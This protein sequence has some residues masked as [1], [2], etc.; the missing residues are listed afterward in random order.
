MASLVVPP[1][2]F[3]A[4]VRATGIRGNDRSCLDF[5]VPRPPASWRAS[6]GPFALSPAQRLLERD[7][8]PVRLGGRALDLL[9]ALVDLAG[10]TV[11]KTE[12]MARVW[13]NAVVDE[14]TLR[15][16]LVAVR[17]A[18]GE[19]LGGQRYIV[20]TASKG[21]TFVAQVVRSEADARAGAPTRRGGNLPAPH[22]TIVGREDEIP[23]LV[24]TLLQHRL[25]SVVGSGGIGKTTVGIAAARDVAHRFDGDVHFVDLSSLA[26]TELVCSSVAAVVGLQ[27]RLDELPAL[28]SHLVDRAALIV[29]DGCEHVIAGA[30]RVAEALVRGC[31]RVHVL[32]TSREALRAGGEF[33]HRLTPLAFPPPGEGLTAAAALAYPAVRLLVERAAASNAGFALSDG[34]ALLASQLCRELDGIALAI[35]LAA[36]RI[37]ALG[38]KTV[39][40]H[41]DASARLMWHGRRT[42][43][44]RQQTL[45]ATLDWSYA[46]LDDNEQR[47]LR[48]L[49]IFAGS[50]SME[51]AITTCCFDFVR[52]LGMDLL[53]GLVAKS[54]VDVDAGG[55]ALRYSL[56]DTTKAYASAK[57]AECG[58]VRT[59]TRRF[60]QFFYELTHGGTEP[61]RDADA[62]EILPSE[63]PNVRAALQWYFEH[64]DKP[65]DAVR[66]AA[67]FCPILLQRSLLTECS[68]C[69]HAA[70]SRLP[71]ELVGSRYEA[72]LQLHRA[73]GETLSFAGRERG[74][75]DDAFRRGIEVTES[76]GDRH[77]AIRLLNGH[78]VYLHRGGRFA[79]ALD[80][81]HRAEA[82]QRELDDPEYRTIV[83]SLVGGSLHLVGR[84]AEA[85]AY[86]ERAVAATDAARSNTVSRL[87]FAH[88]AR[89]LTVLA[90]NQWLTGRCTTAVDTARAAMAHARETGHAVTQCL[91]WLW[92]GQVFG[93]QG[94]VA[95]QLQALESLEEVAR[96]HSLSPYLAAADGVR[97]Q[98]LVDEGRAADGVERLRAAL[99][100]LHAS[101]Y[102]MLTTQSMT[103]LAKGLSALSLHAASLAMCDEAQRTIASGGDFL[104]MPEL[105]IVRGRALAAAGDSAESTASLAA[106]LALARTQGASSLQVRAA[107]ALAEQLMSQGRAAEADA[108]L[109]T[110]LDAAAD[111]ASPDLARARLLRRRA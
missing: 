50:F 32:A 55:A 76:L 21:Y 106:A 20:N 73:L 81:A 51:A 47:L 27:N 72:L 87:G 24:A 26:S 74:C 75:T 89:S 95:S 80:S 12:L 77:A 108:L 52:S 103:A 63:L 56:L 79:E 13:P 9:I 90:R 62:Q 86:L 23:S 18:L 39:T 66:F 30:A 25:V 1:R 59:V 41:F 16:H 2:L 38:L 57:L 14:G 45:S 36:G 85:Q 65:A 104:R 11:G 82:L 107:L 4:D 35:E 68:R 91:A 53:A 110:H 70:I 94:D 78:A 46:L 19:G 5:Q 37:E 102:E 105:L 96:R 69:A 100:A 22:S 61:A 40:S 3:A 98:I 54:L 15:F 84:V 10:E 42:A 111:E 29:L 88:H 109:D 60:A 64:D 8:V 83:D 71:A 93:W 48:R 33:V 49:S 97:G 44:P 28:A 6:F 17:K 43:V 58:E 99:E 101:H 92:A 7:G 31:P 67:S 34:D